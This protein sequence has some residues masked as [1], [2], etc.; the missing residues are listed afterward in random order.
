MG[1]AEDELRRFADGLGHQPG[2][3]GV[4]V[5]LQETTE[6]LEVLGRMFA[7]AVLA[8]EVGDR[9]MTWPCHGRLS[10]A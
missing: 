2:E 6:A 4:A 9:R 1:P 3:A 7:L 10:T 5:H 8:V